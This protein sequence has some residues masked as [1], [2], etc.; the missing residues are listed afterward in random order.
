MEKRLPARWKTWRLLS[1]NQRIPLA[2]KTPAGSWLSRKFETS[3]GR[4]ACAVKG[5]GR[6][7]LDG[8]VIGVGMVV[9]VPVIVGMAVIVIVVVLAVA[10]VVMQC[11]GRGD[12]GNGR[13]RAHARSA[14]SWSQSSWFAARHLVA[15]KEAHAEQQRQVDL[16]DRAQDPRIGLISRSL[17]STAVRRS[18]LTRSHLLSRGCRIDHLAR[19]TSIEDLVAEV[20]GIDQR[21]DG[22]QPGLIP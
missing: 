3:L 5:E 22:V 20:L 7:S 6:E 9:G 14:C 11:C 19:A 17:A 10:V 12:R 18:S 1:L 15:F 13:D 4:K 2:R 16:L 8:E 21:D